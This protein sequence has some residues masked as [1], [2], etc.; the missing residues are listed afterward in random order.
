MPL[1]RIIMPVFNRASVVRDAIASIYAQQCE[2]WELV[3]VDDGSTDDT[4]SVLQEMAAR[5]SRIRVLHQENQGA[6]TA[7]NVGLEAKGD[8]DIV[9][10]LD[11]DD[12]W[13][14]EHLSESLE[15]FR[16]HPEIGAVFGRTV[17]REIKG[18]L[19]QS[20]KARREQR[21]NAPRRFGTSFDEGRYY[22]INDDAILTGL[23]MAE[24]RPQTPTV[25]L[26]RAAL[27]QLRFDTQLMVL[28]DIFLWSELAASGVNFVYCDRPHAAVRL[29]GDNLT[30]ELGLHDSRTLRKVES[31]CRFNE[32]LLRL[33]RSHEQVRAV[34]RQ[35]ANDEYLKAQCYSEQR[36]PFR[37]VHTYLRSI[38]YGGGWKSFRSLV[39]VFI[40]ENVKKC[41]RGTRTAN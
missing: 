21:L 29:Y 41:L 23:L 17:T 12:T 8:C 33:C 7:R 18:K 28:E 13:E 19:S 15:V 1:V 24:L 9:A 14:P 39:G 4:Q 10:F 20:G 36:Y 25:L 32:R 27:A 31:V 37:A 34:R 16:N 26:R 2:D 38:Q 35:I 3:A 6:A 11:S 22:L 40:P 5:D 30:T